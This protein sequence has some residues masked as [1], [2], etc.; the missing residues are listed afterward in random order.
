MTLLVNT[1]LPVTS[2]ADIAQL[3]PY[4][5]RQSDSAVVRDAWVAMLTVLFKE[6]QKYAEYAAKQSDILYATGMY[7]QGLGADRGVFKQAGED[8]ETYR[9]RILSTPALVTPDAIMAAVNAILAPYTVKKA[10]YFEAALDRWF[11]QDGTVTAWH[12]F[13]GSQPQYLDRMYEVDAAS[14][15]GQFIPSRGVRGAWAFADNAGR[16]FL[17]RV[18]DIAGVESEHAFLLV[19]NGSFIAD[20]SNASGTE[21]AGTVA[22][23]TFSDRKVPQDVYDT[24]INMV[25]RIKATS[26]RWTLIVDPTL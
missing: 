14:N 3:L 11:V 13:I 5:V 19:G 25:N 24:I 7:L 23:F 4:F 15:G 8:D 18:P 10:N 20:G 1:D 2:E 6:Y 22:T 12:S 16:H 26:M 21:A 17:I 9:A